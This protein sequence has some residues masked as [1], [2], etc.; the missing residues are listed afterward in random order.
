MEIEAGKFL[1]TWL[2]WVVIIV[3]LVSML[4]I[5]LYFYMR[6]KRMSPL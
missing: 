4:G 2:D 3:F 6:E 5:G 1:L